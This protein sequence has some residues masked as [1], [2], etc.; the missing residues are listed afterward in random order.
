MKFPKEERLHHRSLVEGLFREGHSFYEFPFR[1][2]WRILSD[3]Q[4]EKTF[5]HHVPEKIGPLQMMVTVPKKKRKKAVHRVLMRRR[6]REAY[7]LNRISLRQ[8]I[9]GNPNIRTMG[10]AFVYIHDK[11]LDFGTL[12]SK[13]KTV[14]AKLMQKLLSNTQ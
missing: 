8:E 2:S 10:I 12:D 1:V 3:P 7:R 13:M 11:N 6:I 5:C 14:I 9:I 4:L